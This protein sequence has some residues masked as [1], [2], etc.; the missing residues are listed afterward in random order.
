LA[1]SRERF[2]TELTLGA[3]PGRVDLRKRR[4][5]AGK[6]RGVQEDLPEG[7]LVRVVAQAPDDVTSQGRALDAARV[8]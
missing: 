6:L 5:D 8:L 4:D 2:L 1:P 7:E 3:E